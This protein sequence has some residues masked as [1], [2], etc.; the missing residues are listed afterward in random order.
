MLTIFAREKGIQ[1]V[2]QKTK[3]NDFVYK[4]STCCF[5]EYKFFLYPG[6]TW[7]K[8]RFAKI[9]LYY[10]IQ[11]K[12]ILKIIAIQY[13]RELILFQRLGGIVEEQQL[14]FDTF[15]Y[16]VD[17]MIRY[18]EKSTLVILLKSL[19]HFLA[20]FGFA[21][22]LHYC[23]ITYKCLRISNPYKFVKEP[24][25]LS[26]SMGGIVRR[27]YV[28]KSEVLANLT[29]VQLYILQKLVESFGDYL[30]NGFSPFYLSIEQILCKYIE[31]HFERKVMSST[32]L[33]KF[34]FK[35]GYSENI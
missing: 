34:F 3:K 30:P 15:V 8:L 21:P 26:A 35:F 19:L 29:P 11:S 31:Y 16:Y 24:I 28:K 13:L 32:T 5:I 22:Q 25:S 17:K 6:K 10:P 9:N 1:K 18:P 33:N 12:S 14:L 27:S 2:V 7:D 20:L 4:F 23:N